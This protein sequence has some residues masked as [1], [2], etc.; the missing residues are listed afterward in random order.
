MEIDRAALMS[1][2]LSDADDDLARIEQAVLLLED[3]PDDRKTVDAIFRA[4]HT[5]KGNAS[6]LALDPFAE[7]AHVLEDVLDALRARR[8]DVTSALTTVVL[9][10]VDAL[11]GML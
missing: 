7:L 8:V 1:V 10:S 6:I 3:Q 4:A 2:F 11:R 5:L 9:K